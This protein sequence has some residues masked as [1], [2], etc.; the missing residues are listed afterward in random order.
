MSSNSSLP[1]PY[2]QASETADET[3]FNVI[4][5]FDLVIA[6]W[7]LVILGKTFLSTPPDKLAKTVIFPFPA[8]HKSFLWVL[9]C[10]LLI[11]AAVLRALMCARIT[12]IWDVAVK[13]PTDYRRSVG[14]LIYLPEILTMLSFFCYLKKQE[15]LYQWVN[16]FTAEQQKSA[17]GLSFLLVL[18]LI[19]NCMTLIFGAVNYREAY[20]L[21]DKEYFFA[22]ESA[23]AEG[24][25]LTTCIV[26]FGWK[27]M[28]YT[29]I[30][31]KFLR[32]WKG[33]DPS[34]YNNQQKS[35]TLGYAVVVTILASSI[36]SIMRSVE[37]DYCTDEQCMWVLPWSLD[38]AYAV[39]IAATLALFV[40]TWNMHWTW[41]LECL[42]WTI[43]NKNAV[44]KQ[45][46]LDLKDFKARAFLGGVPESHYELANPLNADDA[47]TDMLSDSDSDNADMDLKRVSQ[48]KTFTSG[49]TI[50]P[51]LYEDN[52]SERAAIH[53]H[54]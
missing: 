18:A 30:L 45:E 31:A 15:S 16:G 2:V 38:T 6:L 28:T 4:A 14:A 24:S 43:R 8:I 48:A 36:A 29:D 54:L 37:P 44:E 12:D 53:I 41:H 46:A 27:S 3:A 34:E 19:A 50:V 9:S 10:L 49:N 26:L 13:D 1:A 32:H 22:W 5:I 52:L 33:A 47:N 11:A 23:R 40:C 42:L 7:A 21:T 39:Q 20:G 17:W 35:T 51:M 25:I